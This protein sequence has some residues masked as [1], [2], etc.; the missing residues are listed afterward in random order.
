MFSALIETCFVRNAYSSFCAF[1]NLHFPAWYL[2]E[3]TWRHWHTAWQKTMLQIS[4][5]YAAFYHFA[6]FPCSSLTN[7]QKRLVATYTDVLTYVPVYF[8][9]WCCPHII[10]TSSSSWHYFL[11]VVSKL[12]SNSAQNQDKGSSNLSSWLL[13]Q[14]CPALEVF[15]NPCC[16]K[17]RATYQAIFGK[18]CFGAFQITLQHCIHFYKNIIHIWYVC[19]G[20]NPLGAVQL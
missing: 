20:T 2:S 4:K 6:T 9:H 19:I 14:T 13:K 7:F 11:R 3:C 18:E 16:I 17:V 15:L 12:Q 1:R 10:E 5:I 8:A